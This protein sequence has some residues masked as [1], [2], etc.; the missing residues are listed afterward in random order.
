MFQLPG[1]FKLLRGDV[2][3][4]SPDVLAVHAVQS[5]GRARH[6]AQ[7][8]LLQHRPRRTDE[9]LTV[10]HGRYAQPGN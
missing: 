6:P 4:G 7:G 3:E 2:E 10:A 1:Q 5:R 8:G 9:E